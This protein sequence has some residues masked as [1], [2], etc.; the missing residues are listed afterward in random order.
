MIQHFLPISC[1]NWNKLLPVEDPLTKRV[2]VEKY[3]LIRRSE[4]HAPAGK[5][6]RCEL[7]RKKFSQGIDAA[8]ANELLDLQEKLAAYRKQIVPLPYDVIDV[9]RAALHSAPEQDVATL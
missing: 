6:R 7:I 3:D 9:L 1:V 2:Y 8:E 4:S 5:K